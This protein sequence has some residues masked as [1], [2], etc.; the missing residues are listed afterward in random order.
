MVTEPADKQNSQPP[1][2][3]TFPQTKVNT[4]DRGR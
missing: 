3:Y 4:F 1:K 2:V